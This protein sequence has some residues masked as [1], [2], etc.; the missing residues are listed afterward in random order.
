MLKQW[1]SYTREEVHSIFS[2]HTKFVRQAGTWGLQGMIRVPERRGDW[3]FFVTFGQSQSGHDFDEYITDEGVLCWQTQ[4]SMK[5]SS[6]EVREL[7]GHDASK[8]SVHLFLRTRPKVPYSYLGQLT[9][10][11]HDASREAPVHFMWQIM[12]WEPPPRFC[13]SINLRLE[14]PTQSMEQ[15]AANPGLELISPPLQPSKRSGLNTAM[16][17]ECRTPDYVER[18]ARNR[19]LG[20]AGE[21]QVLLYE[22]KRLTESGR[23]DLAQQIVHVSVVEGD[24]VG[25]DIRSFEADGSP[26]FIE[27]KTTRGGIGTD[28]FLSTRELER[29]RQLD[30][31]YYIYRVFEF[32]ETSG[33]GKIFTLSGFMGEYFEL[34]PLSYRAR[35]K[36]PS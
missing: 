33:A 22:R 12:D 29:S 31:S 13:D 26:R 10:L 36:P 35:V 24:A 9:Y 16:F 32:D 3:V 5:L 2:P 6:P 30:R 7:I 17:K 8:N 18:D 27:V 23:P 15:A 34:L 19:K 4:P 14:Q 11:S 21:H 20:L 25:Y 1:S 28:F